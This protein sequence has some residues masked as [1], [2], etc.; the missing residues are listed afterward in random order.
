MSQKLTENK[1][2]IHAAW[3]ALLF[4]VVANPT[5]FSYVSELASKIDLGYPVWTALVLHALV[6]GLLV[7]A[8]MEVKLPGL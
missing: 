8:S 4:L 2:W 6:F 7:R 1:K 5:V 3:M